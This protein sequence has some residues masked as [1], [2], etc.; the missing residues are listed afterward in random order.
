MIYKAKTTVRF[1]K[2][3]S[4]LDIKSKRIIKNKTKL[5]ELNPYRNKKLHNKHGRILFRIRLKIQNKESRLI[6]EVIKPNIILL[7]LIERKNSYKE[8]EKLLK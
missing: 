4:E 3:F 7:C 2:Q 8:L 5:L 6:Y 1:R